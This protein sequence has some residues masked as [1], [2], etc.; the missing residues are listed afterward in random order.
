M[1][2]EQIA[3]ILAEHQW[4][5]ASGSCEDPAIGCTGCDDWLSDE[6][7]LDNGAFAAHQAGMLEPVIRE[8]EDE[9]VLKGFDLRK[10]TMEDAWEYVSIRVYSILADAFDTLTF[11]RKRKAGD[12]A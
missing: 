3:D 6:N 10:T 1:S 11:W 9:A 2:T 8:R 12:G 4:Y 5:D 7:A